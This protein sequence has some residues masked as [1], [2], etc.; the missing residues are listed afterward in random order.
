MLW[1]VEA[2]VLALPTRRLWWGWRGA[3][4]LA[5][6]R[7]EEVVNFGIGEPPERR[8]VFEVTLAIRAA[9]A[10]EAEAIA[11]ELVDRLTRKRGLPRR[12]TATLAQGGDPW[13][14]GPCGPED[15]EPSLAPF[16]WHAHE[17]S[18]RG[19]RIAWYGGGVR[20]DRVDVEETPERVVLT[21]WASYGPRFTRDGTPRVSVSGDYTHCV[22]VAL[23]AP[24]GE[25]AILD[26]ATGRAPDDI[27]P[28]D[29]IERNARARFAGVRLAAL[30]VR[31][32]S[33]NRV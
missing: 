8:C 27:D 18:P 32:V 33:V 14:D 7:L 5:H 31:P 23:A 6:P 4:D 22:D 12:V 21:L 19:V 26:G 28:F 25:R 9:D 17:P 30:D 24:L 1:R 13:T 2:R 15:F 29:Y 16:G 3:F 10:E 20:L 11:G